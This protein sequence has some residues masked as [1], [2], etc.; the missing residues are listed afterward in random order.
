[1]YQS[2][3]LLTKFY[4]IYI[5]YVMYFFI[6]G[7]VTVLQSIILYSV[8]KA[9]I[10]TIINTSFNYIVRIL[11]RNYSVKNSRFDATKQVHG[12]MAFHLQ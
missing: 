1:M 6:N 7:F 4:I 9:R 10:T 2:V 3:L 5:L 8:R 12:G 11:K